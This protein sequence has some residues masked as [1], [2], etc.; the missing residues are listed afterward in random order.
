MLDGAHYHVVQVSYFRNE[1]IEIWKWR[2]LTRRHINRFPLFGL[3]PLL[4]LLEALSDFGEFFP[5]CEKI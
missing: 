5:R 1:G 3:Q 2:G 4:S